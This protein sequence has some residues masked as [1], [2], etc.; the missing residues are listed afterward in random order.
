MI[1][2]SDL[3]KYIAERLTNISEKDIKFSLYRPRRPSYFQIEMMKQYEELLIKKLKE[4]KR[5]REIEKKYKG[6]YDGR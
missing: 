2:T 4:E 6:G 5:E 3:S 1:T